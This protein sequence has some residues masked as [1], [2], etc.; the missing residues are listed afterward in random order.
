MTIRVQFNIFHTPNTSRLRIN[1]K[2]R[3]ILT[4]NV[5]FR[6]Y[7]RHFAVLIFIMYLGDHLECPWWL[8]VCEHNVWHELWSDWYHQDDIQTV[9]TVS[10]RSKSWPSMW[11]KLWSRKLKT[12]K[13]RV[14]R[15][16]VAW[17]ALYRCWWIQCLIYSKSE[18]RYKCFVSYKTGI[19]M[20]LINFL[21]F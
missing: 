14:F 7:G 8:Y 1:W 19:D 5:H 15:L 12:L 17:S 9:W 10:R 2:L 21:D 6:K 11:S 3:R 18:P 13:I 20:N 16:F 4:Q